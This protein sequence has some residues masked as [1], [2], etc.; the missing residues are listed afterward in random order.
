VVLADDSLSLSERYARAMQLRDDGRPKC[1][2]LITQR[3]TLRIPEPDDVDFL[4]GLDTDERVMRYIHDGILSTRYARIYAENVIEIA[5]IRAHFHRWIIQN[6]EQSVRIG[7]IELSKYGQESKRADSSDDVQLSY[8]ISPERWNQGYATEAGKAVLEYAFGTIELDR[9]V[10]YTRPENA[11]SI[12]VLQNLSFLRDGEC[13]D[14]A[15]NVCHFYFL[16]RERWRERR[17]R[18]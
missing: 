7:W 9:V 15:R 3:L 6:R 4:T 18:S 16:P 1:P 8:E 13:T 17:D 11:R 10:A 2:V 12:R 5:P 14:G